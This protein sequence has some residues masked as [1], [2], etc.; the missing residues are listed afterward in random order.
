VPYR[1]NALLPLDKS[2]GHQPLEILYYQVLDAPLR[3]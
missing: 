2:L 3:A 1:R